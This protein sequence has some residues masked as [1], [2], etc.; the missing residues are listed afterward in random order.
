MSSRKLFAT[1]PRTHRAR[2]HYHSHLINSGC[3][4]GRR[5]VKQIVCVCVEACAKSQIVN[6]R[7]FIHSVREFRHLNALAYFHHV[8]QAR[9]VTYGVFGIGCE[10]IYIFLRSGAHQGEHQALGHKLQVHKSKLWQN[11]HC[12]LFDVSQIKLYIKKTDERC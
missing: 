1:F 9:A 11:V 4:R 8:V 6:S 12:V 3:G 7:H 2:A 10:Y 5:A